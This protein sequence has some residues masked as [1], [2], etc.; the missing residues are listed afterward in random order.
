MSS[1]QEDY[2]LFS[3]KSRI[4]SIP[5]SSKWKRNALLCEKKERKVPGRQIWT[6]RW[7]FQHFSTKFFVRLSV[8]NERPTL[9][10]RS[11]IICHPSGK[12][13]HQLFELS[14]A[15]HTL[16]PFAD[17]CLHLAYLPQSKTILLRIP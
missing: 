7:V 15:Y 4:A 3:R 6:I 1:L 12:L 16:I 11:D 14:S 2:G 10:W 5:S 9:S 13:L 17:N 8:Q